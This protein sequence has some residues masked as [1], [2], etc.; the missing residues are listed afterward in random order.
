MTIQSRE[1]FILQ[2]LAILRS[3]GFC[4]SIDQRNE[5]VVIHIPPCRERRERRGE[6]RERRGEER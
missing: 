5:I 1:I 4:S 2:K 3:V 6:E